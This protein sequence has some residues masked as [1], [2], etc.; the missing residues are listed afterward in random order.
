MKWQWGNRDS[1]VTLDGSGVRRGSR[2]RQ[3]CGAR[4]V[5][6][7]VLEERASRLKASEG[8]R[9]TRRP[10]PGTRQHAAPAGCHGPWR[11]LAISTSLE[12]GAV[13]ELHRQAPAAFDSEPGEKTDPSLRSEKMPQM[14]APRFPHVAACFFG[15]PVPGGVLEER[16][17]RLKASEGERATRRPP[18]GTSPTSA[19]PCGTKTPTGF[20]EAW[21]ARV[22]GEER[23][24]AFTYVEAD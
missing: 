11:A 2:L 23:A 5:P 20:P 14:F 21:S 8:E 9:A 12:P 10:P 4:P 17:S 16:A 22:H 13:G 18:P 3:A 24:R 1:G 19:D 15:L 7:G 6:G